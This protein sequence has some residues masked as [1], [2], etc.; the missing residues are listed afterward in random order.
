MNNAMRPNSSIRFR[1][2][3]HNILRNISANRIKKR[4]ITKFSK[5]IGI[6]YFGTVDQHKDEHRVVRGFTVS[7]SHRDY[8]YS[9]GSVDGYDVT[10]VDR[11]DLMAQKDGSVVNRNW[12][13]MAFDLHTKI[14]VPHI[15][16][17]SNGH[18]PAAYAMLFDIFPIL[19]PVGLG[20]FEDYN[21]E[22]TSRFTIYAQPSD[23]IEVERLIPAKTARVLSAHLWPYSAEIK[24]DVLYIY[25]SDN[26]LSQNTLDTILE[27]GIWLAK[28]IDSQIESIE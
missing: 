27:I 17:N 14:D 7:P 21:P 2:L 23:F 26:H 20:T 4:L 15:F 25:S 8:H 1:H 22:F 28:Q 19:T 5:K 11:T 18:N 6:I 16:I 13:I 9:V 3:T 12:L 24:D 10:L